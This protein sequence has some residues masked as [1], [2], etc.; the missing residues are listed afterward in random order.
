MPRS[1]KTSKLCVTG[2]CAGN[3]PGPVNSPHK[4]PVT[5]EMFTFDDVIM[6]DCDPRRRM[7]VTQHDYAAQQWHGTS[8]HCNLAWVLKSAMSRLC[9]MIFS[10]FV[11]WMF[12]QQALSMPWTNGFPIT[13][14][15][16][17][18]SQLITS[19]F[20][21]QATIHCE[22]SSTYASFGRLCEINI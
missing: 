6:W 15:S 7:G 19:K 9:V 22:K 11:T 21:I 3:S 17:V 16:P 10:H 20:I 8:C 5:R 4:G 18:V 12:T 14:D 2:L 13:G 1:K